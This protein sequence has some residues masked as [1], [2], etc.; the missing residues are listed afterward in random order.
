MFRYEGAFPHDDQTAN[1]RASQEGPGL[2]QDA[3]DEVGV[4]LR[5]SGRH[6]VGGANS[7]RAENHQRDEVLNH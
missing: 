7:R 6:D 5:G 2:D 4:E 3:G 1:R